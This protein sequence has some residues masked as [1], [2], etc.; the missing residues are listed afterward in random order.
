MNF[1]ISEGIV[2]IALSSWSQTW[3]KEKT[4]KKKVNVN[5][6]IKCKQPKNIKDDQ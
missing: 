5:I 2:E 3:Q 6:N 4:L 1:L